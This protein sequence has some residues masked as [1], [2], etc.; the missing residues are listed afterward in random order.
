MN[1][2]EGDT[3]KKPTTD[4]IP[5][6]ELLTLTDFGPG[7]KCET[8]LV[9]S[10]QFLSPFINQTTKALFDP[11]IR[12]DWGG[13]SVCFVYCE[14]SFWQAQYA[15]WNLEKMVKSSEVIFKP[16]PGANHFV[17]PFFVHLFF[18]TI[19]KRFFFLIIVDVGRTRT[20]HVCYE[21]ML[22][23]LKRLASFCADFVLSLK[24]CKPKWKFPLS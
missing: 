22:A 10:Q 15:P 17:R 23:S 3:S 21:G 14:A 18:Q 7:P 11:Q 24:S 16:I 13:H 5:L 1:Q 4:T 9:D 6:E 12:E 19:L 2:R 8:F 20:I